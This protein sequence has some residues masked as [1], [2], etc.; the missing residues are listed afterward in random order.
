MKT[1]G[2]AAGHGQGHWVVLGRVWGLT[3]VWVTPQ[4]Q[5]L[6]GGLWWRGAECALA[7]HHSSEVGQGI[8]YQQG[9]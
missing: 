2:L 4:E 7:S 6:R 3:W 1:G 5:G 9:G 8:G